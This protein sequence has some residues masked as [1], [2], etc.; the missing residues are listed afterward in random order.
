MPSLDRLNA[1]PL[2]IGRLISEFS[3]GFA[4]SL[5]FYRSGDGD[6]AIARKRLRYCL[7]DSGFTP[8]RREGRIAS[9]R[10]RVGVICDNTTIDSHGPK[11]LQTI[12]KWLT[13]HEHLD[14]SLLSLKSGSRNDRKEIGRL[15]RY[16]GKRFSAK[17]D[18]TPT[19]ISMFCHANDWIALPAT[20]ANFGIHA[21][22][23]L[24]C[25]TPVIANNIEPF[26]EIVENGVNGFLV[27]GHVSTN[28]ANAPTITP[29]F[30][31]WS[32]L[33]C[34]LFANAKTLLQ[35]Q[36]QDWKIAQKR[37]AFE[38]VWRNEFNA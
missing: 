1:F 25:G 19:A 30:H 29:A 26:S 3:G 15:L 27:P 8:V 12:C 34:N 38:Q 36:T 17:R 18:T 35:L 22:H 4:E 20:R 9:N 2:R 10:I 37:D 32:E 24:A 13:T 28:N 31:L 16:F 14:V 33:G 11:L 7:W 23:A 21:A 6:R 5:G